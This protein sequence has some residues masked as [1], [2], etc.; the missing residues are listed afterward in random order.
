MKIKEDEELP[1]SP[2]Q[3]AKFVQGVATT[4]EANHTNKE[5]S[6]LVEARARTEG[7]Q[8]WDSVSSIAI[9]LKNDSQSSEVAYQCS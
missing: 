2:S 4:Q 1:K 8:A 9:W 3:E 7:S 5:S 6:G